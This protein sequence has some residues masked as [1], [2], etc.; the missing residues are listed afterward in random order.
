MTIVFSPNGTITDEKCPACGECCKVHHGHE[1]EL[2]GG[3]VYPTGRLQHTSYCPL[4]G[5][6]TAIVC[7]VCEHCTRL[8]DVADKLKIWEASAQ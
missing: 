5:E 2:E 1:S 3:K 4:C 6:S 7:Y 8:E